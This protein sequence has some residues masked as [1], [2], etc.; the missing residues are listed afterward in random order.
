MTSA[1]SL[2]EALAAKCK[3]DIPGDHSQAHLLQLWWGL[4]QD[5]LA[6]SNREI[7]SLRRAN[8]QL[9]ARLTQTIQLLSDQ[10][11][12][13]GMLRQESA[14]QH[15]QIVEQL[16]NE[17]LAREQQ[18]RGMV[19]DVR[20]VISEAKVD[21]QKVVRDACEKGYGNV[22]PV[23]QDITRST[24]FTRTQ[25]VNAA[26]GV[27]SF[28][29]TATSVSVPAAISR[30]QTPRGRSQS[31]GRSI[32][33]PSLSS[34]LPSPSPLK[35]TTTIHPPTNIAAPMTPAVSVAAS[36]LSMG[37]TTLPFSPMS[38]MSLSSHG[39]RGFMR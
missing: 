24:S 2:E 39:S 15:E 26:V 14:A 34:V 13:V 23:G 3:D 32:T 1:L 10:Q 22:L 37:Q 19:A 38:P 4:V 21:L 17:R 31:P 28:L 18:I 30:A 9:E 33:A 7:E 6:S 20:E 11:N 29:S 36:S 8:S 16:A 5:Q 35:T 25:R 27:P 12:R